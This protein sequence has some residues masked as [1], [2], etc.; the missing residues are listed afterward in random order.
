MANEPAPDVATEPGHRP[1]LIQARRQSVGLREPGPD[2]D[3]ALEPVAPLEQAEDDLRL[4]TRRVA[5]LIDG[6]LARR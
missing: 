5:A 1:S 6:E 4:H 2:F 3:L